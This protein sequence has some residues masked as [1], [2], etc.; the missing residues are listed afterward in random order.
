MSAKAD[1]LPMSSRADKS[2]MPSQ[3]D[4]LSLSFKPDKFLASS[5]SNHLPL[6][7][8][9]IPVFN[10]QSTLERCFHSITHQTYSHLQ[11]IF[12]ND[13]STD[14]S[15]QLCDEFAARDYRVQVIHRQP[16]PAEA[17]PSAARNCGLA[18]AEGQYITFLDADDVAQPELIALL[19]TLLQTAQASISVCSFTEVYPDGR[20]RPFAKAPSSSQRTTSVLKPRLKSNSSHKPHS[21]PSHESDSSR[22]SDSLELTFEVYSPAVALTHLLCEDGFMMSIW[23]KLYARELFTD[24][25]FPVGQ[26]YEDVGTTYRLFLKA[27]QIAFTPYSAYDYYQNPHSIIHQA[28]RPEKLALIQLTD[29][30]CDDILDSMVFQNAPLSERQSLE[31]ALQK[32][33][34]HARFSILRQF[35]GKTPRERELQREMAAYIRAHADDILKNPLGAR[36]DVIATRALQLSTPLFLLLWKLYSRIRK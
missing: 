26:L 23:G 24:I 22:D 6:I 1:K 36:R 19:Y 29:T 12:I 33:R 11:I 32:R 5:R 7:T 35:T 30:M 28:F 18:I 16:D 13:G 17:G 8:V 20:R 2:P 15:V 25:R 31:Y 14:G 27:N 21:D 34:L 3:P 4:T 10:N 9:I